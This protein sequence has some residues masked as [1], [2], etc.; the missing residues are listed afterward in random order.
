[1]KK[2]LLLSLAALTLASCGYSLQRSER[3]PF[4][5]REGIHRIFVAPLENNTFKAGVENLV[6]NQIVKVFASNR[7]VILVRSETDAD[8]VLRG[9]VGS[10]GYSASANVLANELF[11]KDRVSG[12]PRGSAD[13]RVA[14][15]YVGS[16]GC[17]FSLRRLVPA[18][19][20][21]DE[22]WS[23]SFNRSK[24]FPGNNQLD[25]FG[26]TSALINESEFDRVLKDLAEALSGDLHEAML[27]GF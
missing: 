16:L 4:F 15:E 21:K 17:S 14:T 27:A 3:P 19:G 10:A 7:R 5:Q 18:A 6:Y 9:W 20:K 8:A 2:I 12:I 26:N 13:L 22:V 23:G 24:V 25:L 11:P 1:M